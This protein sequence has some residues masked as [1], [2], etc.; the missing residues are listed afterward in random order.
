MVC[1]TWK[2]FNGYFSKS[3]Y[4]TYQLWLAEHG[5]RIRIQNI[6]KYEVSLAQSGRLKTTAPTRGS[7]DEF[8]SKFTAKDLC[9]TS[10]LT[11]TMLQQLTPKPKLSSSSSIHLV[12]DSFFQHQPWQTP[13]E[14]SYPW[15]SSGAI[16]TVMISSRNP[17]FLVTSIPMK[18]RVAMIWSYLLFT[19]FCHMFPS[20]SHYFCKKK[21]PD[22][23]LPTG[24][25]WPYPKRRKQR[26]DCWTQFPSASEWHWAAAT[27]RCWVMKNTFTFFW[28]RW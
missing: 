23:P 20:C 10:G 3:S 15:P 17:T 9:P 19:L 8:L 21:R 2:L 18:P 16:L 25:P 6:S 28:Y 24:M 1:Q 26:Q 7:V 4:E 12:S 22:I 11:S 14:A 5:L 13:Q 27:L